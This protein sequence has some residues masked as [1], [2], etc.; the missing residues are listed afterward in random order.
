MT[1]KRNLPTSTKPIAFSLS[2]ETAASLEHLINAQSV[3]AAA[4][5]EKG[6]TALADAIT[7]VTPFW[8]ALSA[9]L[10]NPPK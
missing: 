1:A 10:A 6:R 9:Y 4:E 3:I 5:K 2:Y 8:N 7:R